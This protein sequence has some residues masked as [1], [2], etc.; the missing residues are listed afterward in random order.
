MPRHCGCFNPHPSRR[1]GATL[2]ALRTPSLANVSILTRPEGRALPSLLGGLLGQPGVS[3]LTRPEG[4]A[5][6]LT[7][8]VSI[9][10]TL[11][12]S[13]PVP[14]DGRYYERIVDPPY[15]GPVSILTRPEGRALPW[16]W[17]NDPM[18]GE[19][20]NPHPSRRT[21]A[22]RPAS[23]QLSVQLCFNP[24]P[25][26]RTGATNPMGRLIGMSMFQSSPVP[27]DGRYHSRYRTCAS[28]KLFQS[29]PVPKDG[30]YDLHDRFWRVCQRVSILTRP[31]GR[32][33]RGM[34]PLN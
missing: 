3:I 25:S 21:G 22:T 27:K 10:E 15:R 24:H 6:P 30:R 16:E 11:F 18:A 20:F 14:K 31:E 12:Q 33:L 5:L 4:R 28:A 2:G 29:S 19:R 32:A 34:L 17:S 13:S 9:I 23:S 8:S 1:T 26:R 7:T